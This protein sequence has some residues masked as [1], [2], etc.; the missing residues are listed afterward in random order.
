[1]RPDEP[2]TF[3]PHEP[4]DLTNEAKVSEMTRKLDCSPSELAE[5]VQKVGPQPVAVAIFL[6]RPDALVLTAS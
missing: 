3:D 6:G 5:A 1:M 2:K 4:I